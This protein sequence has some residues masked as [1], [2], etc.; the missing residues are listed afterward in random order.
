[1]LVDPET[2]DIVMELPGSGSPVFDLAFLPGGERLANVSV[3]GSD[4][5]LGRQRR[6]P[7]RMGGARNPHRASQWSAVSHPMG[8]KWRWPHVNPTASS[9]STWTLARPSLHSPTSRVFP[10]GP[11]VSPDW[12]YLGS[13]RGGEAG[14]RATIRDL[15]SPQL[16]VVKE[17]PPCTSVK[18][19]SPDSSLVL[20]NGIGVCNEDPPPGAELR[21]RV[22]EVESGREV[23]DL[24]ESGCT[25]QSSTR[26][27]S[28][29][30]VATWR[31]PRPV[32]RCPSTTWRLART[33]PP[34]IHGDMGITA[35]LDPWFDPEGRFLLPVA[36][37]TA[38]SGCSTSPRWS[39]GPRRS[40]LSIFNQVRAHRPRSRRRRSRA[41]ASW[42]PPASIR[43]CGC[44]TSIPANSLVE[45]R[46]ATAAYLKWSC[47]PMGA[48]PSTPTGPCSVSS[49][50]TLNGS[51]RWLRAGSPAS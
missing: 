4:S 2:G 18:A 24:G 25:P 26:R 27:G 35:H 42:P 47:R 43:W 15:A 40:T 16:E 45:F 8:H 28:F 50:S 34:W 7:A 37:S 46:S 48:M 5:G 17:L 39:T 10:D 21:S 1:M 23:L 14:A 9:C 13:L 32:A 38:S 11:V 51:S 44:G 41:M 36:R 19:F 3:D 12:R 31:S 22:V 33:L 30:P 6:W 49:I 29:L 20:L